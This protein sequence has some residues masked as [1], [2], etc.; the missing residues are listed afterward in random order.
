M[1]TRGQTVHKPA[2]GQHECMAQGRTA[3][4]Q[5]WGSRGGS[6][7]APE[8]AKMTT[9]RSRGGVKLRGR[10]KGSTEV[11]RE[12]WLGSRDNS[13][14]ACEMVATY[15]GARNR[16]TGAG[17]RAAGRDPRQEDMGWQR[18]AIWGRKPERRGWQ[19]GS[20]AAR[21]MCNKEAFGRIRDKTKRFFY[22]KGKYG[23]REIVE[24]YL[25]IG[26]QWSSLMVSVYIRIWWRLVVICG[27]AGQWRSIRGQNEINAKVWWPIEGGDSSSNANKLRPYYTIE[28]AVGINR[29]DGLVVRWRPYYTSE[30][31]INRPDDLVARWRPYYTS[32]AEI[33]RP[34]GLIARWRPY[35]TSETEINRP[36]GLV[37]RWRHCRCPPWIIRVL[38]ID[39]SLL[40]SHQDYNGAW[41]GFMPETL[42]NM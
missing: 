20:T 24:I 27:G 11:P 30:A 3:L 17:T 32:E 38:V 37:A 6:T 22:Y 5:F 8:K 18:A 4:S 33:N 35:Y 14:C 29:P 21:V 10:G 42:L 26:G 36:D 2:R 13:I 31:E 16:I 34:D 1:L 28:E 9:V 7:R 12:H 23:H 39:T 25:S 19:E 15:I 41:E 40:R